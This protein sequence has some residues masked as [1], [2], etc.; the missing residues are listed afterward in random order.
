MSD[1]YAVVGNPV[2]HSRSPW[3]HARFARQTG[4]DIDYGALLSPREEFARTVQAFRVAGAKGAN[5][6]LPFKEEAYRL[7]GRLSERAR[8]AEAVNT[9]SFHGE[10]VHGDNT[11]G[12]GLTRDLA[13]NL[14]F[15]M[16]GRRILLLGAGGAARGVVLPLMEEKPAV[17]VIA[18]RDV[19][20]AR[21]LARRFGGI[22][23]CAYPDLAGEQFDLVINATSAG[24]AQATLPLPP[25][26]FA[27]G[28]LAY[29]M[30]YGRRTEFM[31]Q[32][33]ADGAA[34][35]ADGLGMLVEQAAESFYV[36]R[37]VRPETA[38]VLASLRAA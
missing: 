27:E 1:R 15:N 29:E 2:E 37:G 6:T 38:S 12:C 5:V 30:V 13:G 23:A 7:S 18:N 31:R 32:A 24:L 33:Q 4:E 3:I 16:A 20:K 19:A 8:A 11:D 21:A 28:S 17:L 14:G 9:L 22:S 34:S 10:D 36:W 35:T 26:L 25:G